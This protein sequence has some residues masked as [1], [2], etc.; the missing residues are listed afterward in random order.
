VAENESHGRRNELSDWFADYDQISQP[1]SRQPPPAEQ[2]VGQG[3]EQDYGG[4]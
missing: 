1:Q 4:S 2:V 3:E